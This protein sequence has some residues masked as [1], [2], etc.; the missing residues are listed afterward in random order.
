MNRSMEY[1]L[2]ALKY[3]DVLSKLYEENAVTHKKRR[4]ELDGSSEKQRKT[5]KD[6]GD[7]LERC[8]NHIVLCGARELNFTRHW[9]GI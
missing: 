6:Q 5:I 9:G 2:E 1:T 7:T 3:N 4:N 8:I